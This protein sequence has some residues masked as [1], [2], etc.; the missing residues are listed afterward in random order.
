[1]LG[2]PIAKPPLPVESPAPI[3][4]EESQFITENVRQFYGSDP[5]GRCK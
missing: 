3:K 1:M 4:P 2:V 5:Q